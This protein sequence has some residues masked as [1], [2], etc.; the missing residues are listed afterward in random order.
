MY[1]LKETRFAAK[2]CSSGLSGVGLTE[3]VKTSVCT[4]FGGVEAFDEDEYLK[5]ALCCDNIGL[6][7][8][9]DSY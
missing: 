2:S 6:A 3:K 7:G 8:S 9:W 1:L 5:N 4:L